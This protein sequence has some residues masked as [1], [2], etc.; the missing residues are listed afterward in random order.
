MEPLLSHDERDER[1]LVNALGGD[2]RKWVNFESTIHYVRQVPEG[3]QVNLSLKFTYARELINET[4]G[5]D[6]DRIDWNARSVDGG[7]IIP[8]A[9]ANAMDT[10][11]ISWS[12]RQ[13]VTG[14]EERIGLIVV[15]TSVSYNRYFPWELP[16]M[17]LTIQMDGTCNSKKVNL[18][19]HTR[20]GCRAGVFSKETSPLT[21]ANSERDRTCRIYLRDART[22]EERE[23]DRRN[24]TGEPELETSVVVTFLFQSDVWENLRKYIGVACCVTLLAIFLPAMK[25]PEM[26]AT[27]LAMI[28]AI[29]G[30][31]YV[32]PD[33]DEF[34]TTERVLTTQIIGVV[35]MTVWLGVMKALGRDRFEPGDPDEDGLKH[36]WFLP[37]GG[38][39]VTGL[40]VCW[41]ARRFH[42]K[43]QEVTDGLKYEVTRHRYDFPIGLFSKIRD[44]F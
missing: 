44:K 41:E 31:L 18:V 13:L 36:W 39:L 1:A 2:D 29:V 24:R 6:A 40:F 35:F 33:N 20:R 4:F 5:R 23:E 19:P 26:V 30:L 11:Q 8:Y 38:L 27:A 7:S 37:V 15:L 22:T 43:K 12:A 10:H 9:I 14:V 3:L 21:L 16:L 25:I 32:M 28:L 17:F 42:Q 34:T